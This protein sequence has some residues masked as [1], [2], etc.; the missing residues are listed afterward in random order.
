MKAGMPSQTMATSARLAIAAVIQRVNSDEA[1]VAMIAS[2][3]SAATSV[4]APTTHGAAEAKPRFRS[5]KRRRTPIGKMLAAARPFI[6]LAILFAAW[7]VMDPALVE[8]PT[9]LAGDP[10]RISLSFTRCGPGR[11]HACVIDGDTFKIGERKVR[12][13]GIDAPEVEARC[14]EE[15]RLAGLDQLRLEAE[16]GL[17]VTR[18][19]KK[20]D[21]GL[22]CLRHLRVIADWEGWQTHGHALAPFGITLERLLDQKLRLRIDR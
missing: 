16:L 22:P 17:P 8:P 10:E 7:A 21:V 11:G 19:D 6:L 18:I 4:A 9:I 5:Q 15:A 12:V 13:I 14:P 20:L 1:F 3:A 2:A